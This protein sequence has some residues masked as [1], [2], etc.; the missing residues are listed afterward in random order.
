M[1][2]TGFLRHVGGPVDRY[3]RRHKLPMLCDDPDVF[4]PLTRAWSFFAD[5][6]RHEDPKLGW[7]VGA[8]IGD[9]NLNVGLLQKLETAPTLFLAL[10]RFV[11]MA[12][13]EASHI[14]LGIHERRGDVLIYT[15][16]SGMRD[17]PGY[18]VSQAYQLELILDLIRHFLGSGWVPEE[19]GIQHP[20]APAIIEEHFP[21]SRILTQ[22]QMGYIAV[23]RVCLN[24]AVRRTDM[25]SY[26]AGDPVL[27]ENLDDIDTL[28]ALLKSYLPDGYPSAWFAAELL[29][30]SER[31]LARRLS[32]RGLTYGTLVDGV[33]FEVAKQLLQKPSVRIGDVA[34]S[35]GFED[36]ANFTRMFRRVGGLTPIEFRKAARC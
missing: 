24:R 4:V 2:F 7:L 22:Q 31:T 1:A 16:Y 11:E 23:P 9:N 32:A 30:V 13:T 21:C 12:R 19:I 17:I 26:I 34:A 8:H 14:E 5:A 35:V 27:K 3:L 29:G 20:I 33:R 36:Q 18:L 10:Q 6:E 25:K 28:R 15:R